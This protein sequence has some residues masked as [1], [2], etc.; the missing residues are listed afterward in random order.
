MNCPTCGYEVTAAEK[1]CPSCGAPINQHSPVTAVSDATSADRWPAVEHENLVASHTDQPDV[2][3][4]EAGSAV[5]KSATEFLPGSPVRLGQGEVIWKQYRA[6]QLRSRSGGEGTLYV[7]DSRVVFYARAKGSGAQR[8]SSLV[9]QT[10]LEDVTGLAAYVS[11]RLSLGLII[12]TVF[13]ALVALL[14]LLTHEALW[15]F[16]WLI[17]FAVCLS[18]LLGSGAKRG[19]AGVIIHARATMASPIGFGYFGNQRGPA[20]WNMFWLPLRLLF[21]AYT[22]FDVMLGAPGEDSGKLIGE[23]GALILDLQT[24]GTLAEGHWDIAPVAGQRSRAIS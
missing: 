7:T 21:R 18:A 24:R 10:K 19:R 20:V 2:T 6:V 3:V 17:I 13:S 11:H 12:A 4:Q 8:E 16:V 1:N 15:T 23:L 22:A 14:G 9:Q 5:G